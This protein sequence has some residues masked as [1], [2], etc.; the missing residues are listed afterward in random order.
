[1][2]FVIDE[3]IKPKGRFIID[4]TPMNT[5]GKEP[6]VQEDGFV[7]S[8]LKDMGGE[9]LGIPEVVAGV[10]TG[11]AAS[12]PAFIGGAVKTATSG[13]EEGRKTREAIQEA[14]TYQPRT[15][16]GQ[17]M[18]SKIGKALTPLSLPRKAGEAI[19]RGIDTAT[20]NK[21]KDWEEG[22]G[23]VAEAPLQALGVKGLQAG[24]AKAGL[25]KEAPKI[26][27]VKMKEVNSQIAKVVKDRFYKGIKPSTGKGTFPQIDTYTKKIAN[28]E[29]YIVENKGNLE[30][31]D[32]DGNLIKGKLP[33]TVIQKGQVWHKAM[34]DIWAKADNMVRA[35]N[36][37]GITVDSTP[38]VNQLRGIAKKNAVAS[39]SVAREALALAERL[40][41][42]PKLNFVEIQDQLGQINSRLSTK[43]TY[44]D[45]GNFQVD[46]AYR[47]FLKG[48]LEKNIN[49]VGELRNLYSAFKA[50]EKDITRAVGRRLNV[51]PQHM[52]FLDIGSM[53]LTAQA[54]MQ[55]NP[56][57]AVTAGVLRG[58]NWYRKLQK[59]PDF[60]TAKMYQKL[61]KIMT[62]ANKFT[63]EL[64]EQNTARLQIPYT[65]KLES[66]DVSGVNRN[67]ANVPPLAKPTTKAIG[68]DTSVIKQGM[69]DEST[70]KAVNAA[71]N[72]PE[73]WAKNKDITNL[74]L[75]MKEG[76]PI[77]PVEMNEFLMRVM[78]KGKP[79]TAVQKIF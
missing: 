75:K 43:P 15:Q 21:T 31:T 70:V 49:G 29:K 1:M 13:G 52:D 55:A 77:A 40:E 26:T 33:E 14:Y 38:F 2:A 28:A 4:D 9:L 48:E 30:F 65:K 60:N 11:A 71:V 41:G 17:E 37:T 79:K 64:P 61:D 56:S 63:N 19:G 54:I 72:N 58:A 24:I 10:A 22:M 51:D 7:M 6:E 8:G 57:M 44:S 68:Y 18:I 27:S 66:T 45:Y 67:P 16:Y 20:G 59:D 39:P 78:L 53:T 46:T 36:G 12:L 73:F 76:K 47:N 42:K 34:Q 69:M 23:N 62:G 35:K 32:V 50:G 25:I 5:E 3:D 74:L